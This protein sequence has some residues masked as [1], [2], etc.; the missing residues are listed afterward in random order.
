MGRSRATCWLSSLLLERRYCCL[1]RLMELGFALAEGGPPLLL[2]ERIDFN[3]RVLL[4][5]WSQH[6]TS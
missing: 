1:R 5:L 3:R 6:P 2:S 4:V